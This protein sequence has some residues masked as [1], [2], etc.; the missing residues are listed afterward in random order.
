MMTASVMSRTS[1]QRAN[2]MVFPSLGPP[3]GLLL[4][5]FTFEALHFG[6]EALLTGGQLAELLVEVPLAGAHALQLRAQLALAT[7][8]P[9]RL[10]L[11]LAPPP[12]QIRHLTSQP[13]IPGRQHFDFL[14]W[15]DPFP[16]TLRRSITTRRPI[17]S[18]HRLGVPK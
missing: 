10:R 5:L 3:L 8:Q 2:M 7:R 14:S 18:L 11:Q 13:T 1:A 4:I 12:V 9:L 17:A 6:S 16:A 15:V